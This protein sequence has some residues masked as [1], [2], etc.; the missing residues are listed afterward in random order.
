MLMADVCE[1]IPVTSLH[2]RTPG[3]IYP[4][5]DSSRRLTAC[6]LGRPH[7]DSFDCTH[8]LSLLLLDAARLVAK[9]DGAGM[10]IVD[11]TNDAKLYYICL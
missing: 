7:C 1:C 3:R 6:L 8:F 4:V 10:R 9:T 11:L 5:H 2:L